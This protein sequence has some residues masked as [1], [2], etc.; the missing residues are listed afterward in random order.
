[1]GISN[2]QHP[3][4]FLGFSAGSLRFGWKGSRCTGCAN[5]CLIRMNPAGQTRAAV[6]T[7]IRNVPGSYPD[8]Y[9]GKLLSLQF[10]VNKECVLCRFM[11]LPRAAAE[12]SI[13]RATPC[14]VLSACLLSVCCL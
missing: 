4:G 10:L 7:P 8:T 9:A 1:M 6:A 5:C 12:S 13:C 11:I 2:P 3:C 14:C